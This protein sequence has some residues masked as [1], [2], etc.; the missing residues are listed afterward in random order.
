[1]PTLVLFSACAL[2]ALVPVL[3]T[4]GAHALTR[5]LFTDARDPDRDRAVGI[6]LTI[7]SLGTML[8]SVVDISVRLPDASAPTI[9]FLRGGVVVAWINSFAFGWRRRFS[10][11]TEGTFYTSAAALAITWWLLRDNVAGRADALCLLGSGVWLLSRAWPSGRG[12]LFGS[13][14][15]SPCEQHRPSDSLEPFCTMGSGDLST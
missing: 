10:A 13:T 1:V 5:G 7:C 9:G 3:A 14:P 8:L 11:A 4:S 6:A 12:K 2:L 15:T